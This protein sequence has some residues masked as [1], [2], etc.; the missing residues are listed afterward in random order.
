[1]LRS[2][3][4]PGARARAGSTCRRRNRGTAGC[5][6]SGRRPAASDW[7]RRAIRNEES[8]MRDE[9]RDTHRWTRG[10]SLPLP[11][12]RRE[13]DGPD[14]RGVP[15]VDEPGRTRSEPKPRPRGLPRERGAAGLPLERARPG[16]PALLLLALGLTLA[17]ASRSQ[18]TS[19]S[20]D[21][22]TLDFG[23]Q[24]VCTTSASTNVTVSSG[25]KSAFGAT[26]SIT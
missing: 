10:G 26:A 16:R 17:L 21:K 11:R 18:A 2:S 9:R 22:S 15:A 7:R 6:T 12:L 14:A 5:G 25:D 4:A 1:P 3:G 13:H 24:G 23:S 8:E 20:V 19:V